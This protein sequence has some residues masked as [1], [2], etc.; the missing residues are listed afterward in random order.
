MEPFNFLSQNPGILSIV[1]FPLGLI[2]TLAVARKYIFTGASAKLEVWFTA[3]LESY[4]KHTE[5]EVKIEERLREL[6]DKLEDMITND[7]DTL[8]L[9]ASR[10]DN[11]DVGQKNIETKIDLITK[12][13]PKRQTD[14]LKP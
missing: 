5:A 4:R 8:R 11:I 13:I 1:A 14:I 6:V 10:F 2:L 12:T 7:R 9:F 3:Y